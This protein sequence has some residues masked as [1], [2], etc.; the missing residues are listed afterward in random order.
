M[1]IENEKENEENKN[2]RNRKKFIDDLFRVEMVTNPPL[3]LSLSLSQNFSESK[4]K[5]MLTW[6]LWPFW[7]IEHFEQHHRKPTLNIENSNKNIKSLI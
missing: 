7:E 3:V 2:L 5:R 6:M 1:Y 4:E